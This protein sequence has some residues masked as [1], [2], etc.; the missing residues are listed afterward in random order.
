MPSMSLKDFT[1]ATVAN[2]IK[3]CFPLA[4]GGEELAK[5][6]GYTENAG[7]PVGA[8]VPDF[9]GQVILDTT[10]LVFYKA[11][12]VANN[13]QWVSITDVATTQFNA[14]AT[15][16]PAAITGAQMA[17]KADNVI[18]MTAA[19]GGAGVLNVDTAVNIIAAMTGGGAVGSS[20]RLR[21]IN[22]SAGAF[23]WTVT[24]AAGVT[25]TG[26]M[27]IAQNTFRDFVITVTAAGA[28]TIQQVG[29]GTTS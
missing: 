27:T 2:L 8:V 23:A 25:L 18:N 28:V 5:A 20:T 17:G 11:I 7:T 14:V 10:G 22:S 9:V 21:I 29:T 16:T 6:I 15:G 13:T 3:V 24:A 26:T 12:G 19:L 4:A 1:K